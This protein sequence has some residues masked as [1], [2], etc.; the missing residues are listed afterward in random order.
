MTCRHR[1]V[2]PTGGPAHRA[3]EKDA[4]QASLERPVR[5]IED[6][7]SSET[8]GARPWPALTPRSSPN[9]LTRAKP[10]ENGGLSSGHHA[11]VTRDDELDRAWIAGLNDRRVRDDPAVR[12]RVG[13]QQVQTLLDDIA[14]VR[15]EEG[16]PTGY[17]DPA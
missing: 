12:A 10:S 6:M 8:C 1:D 11:H 3:G 17:Q 5:S 7:Q 16:L 14:Q 2:V 9:R 13:R 15:E 4:A